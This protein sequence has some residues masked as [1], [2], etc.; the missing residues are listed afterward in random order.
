MKDYTANDFPDTEFLFADKKIGIVLGMPRQMVIEAEIRHHSLLSYCHM[1]WIKE[2]NECKYTT[3]DNS[4]ILSITRERVD[5]RN[6]ILHLFDWINGAFP[7]GV[8]SFR[9]TDRAD[10]PR[11]DANGGMEK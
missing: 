2:E 1:L 11:R 8:C 9:S 6:G 10:G 7:V 3:L 5:L 4:Y